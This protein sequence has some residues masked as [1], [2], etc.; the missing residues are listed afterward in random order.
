MLKLICDAA[1]EGLIARVEEADGGRIVIL[2]RL[3]EAVQ[4]LFATMFLFYVDCTRDAVE[5]VQKRRRDSEGAR[6]RAP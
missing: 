6:P 3:D 1:D 2:R 4:D 5:R